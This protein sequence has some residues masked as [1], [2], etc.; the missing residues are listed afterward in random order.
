MDEGRV[1][2]YSHGVNR[3][4]VS[5]KFSTCNKCGQP[6]PVIEVDGLLYPD[7][8][9]PGVKIIEI[10][11]C[12]RCGIQEQPEQ[13]ASSIKPSDMSSDIQMVINALANEKPC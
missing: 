4:V 13:Q 2:S 12:S 7:A 8:R 10:V 1:P 9:W 6:A 11:N 3:V 5:T